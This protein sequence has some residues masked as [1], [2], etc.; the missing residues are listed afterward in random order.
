[1][2]LLIHLGGHVS[3]IQSSTTSVSLVLG[4]QT[5]AVL[6]GLLG[7]LWIQTQV[8]TLIRQALYKLRHLLSIVKTG[9][10]IF[11]WSP[12]FNSFGDYY[13]L[14]RWFYLHDDILY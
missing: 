5:L 11:L 9:M 14:Q 6:P 1:M 4:L 2:D 12:D 13:I 10:L 3:E 8:V 7:V